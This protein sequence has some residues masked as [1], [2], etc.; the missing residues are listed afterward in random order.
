MN[1]EEINKTYKM[2]DK[3]EIEINLLRKQL[4]T[5]ELQLKHKCKKRDKLEEKLNEDKWMSY[6]PNIHG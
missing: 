4:N 6:N 2:V 1:N 5:V 3:L